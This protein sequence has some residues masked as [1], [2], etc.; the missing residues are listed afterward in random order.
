M[1]RSP[2]GSID[3][4]DYT[5]D[6]LANGFNTRTAK[7]WDVSDGDPSPEGE[8]ADAA[9]TERQVSRRPGDGT[10]SRVDAVNRLG[11]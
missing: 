6:Y 10:L 9:L 2:G 4:S 8:I 11:A 3:T 7:H 1:R 5:Q